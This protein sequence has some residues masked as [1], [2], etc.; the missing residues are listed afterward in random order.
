VLVRNKTRREHITL[1]LAW[2]ADK[3]IQQ[4]GRSHRSNQLSAPIYRLVTTNLGGERRFASAVAKRW[5]RR[6]SA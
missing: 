3:T 1:E 2:S 4:L 5:V 6:H